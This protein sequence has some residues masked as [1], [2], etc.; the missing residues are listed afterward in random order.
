MLTARRPAESVAVTALVVGLAAIVGATFGLAGAQAGLLFAAVLIGAV[1]AYLLAWPEAGVVLGIF[2]IYSGAP[3]VAVNDHGLPQ[4]VALGVPLMLAV[5]LVS[6]LV[7]RQGLVLSGGLRWVLVLLAI[8]IL[9]AVSSEH[10]SLAL[11]KLGN[12]VIEGVAVFFLITNVVRTPDALRRAMWAIVGASTAL[13][14]ATIVQQFFGKDRYFSGFA[15]LDHAYFLGKSDVLRAQ[16][17]IGDPNYYA[18]ILLVAV[19]L[20]L[21][22]IWRGRSHRERLAAGVAACACIAAIAF[23][24]SRGGAL[25]L[26]AVL[27]CLAFFRYVRAVHVAALVAAFALVLVLVPGYSAR[28]DSLTGAVSS[29]ETSTASSTD[30]LS[31]ASRATENKAA[32]LLFEDH[33]LIGVGQGGFPLYYQEYAPRVGGEIH[34]KSSS[35]LRQ[36]NIS[37]GLAPEREAHNF[38]LGIAADMGFAGL[39]GYCAVLAATVVLLLR[40]RRRWLAQRSDLEGLATAMLLAVVGYMVAAVFLSLAF[41]R[42]FWL[43]IALADAAAYMLLRWPADG[44]G[45]AG[46][47]LRQPSA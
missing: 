41:E 30:D 10:E 1:A 8:Q 33:P 35:D 14:A 39:L 31:A 7:A 23:T 16:G 26:F 24:Y 21:V 25:A 6:R 28:L 42:Y 47:G 37:A 43:L 45:D 46:A 5:P 20:S 19:A 12:F 40:A 29:A 2:L 17:P 13:S 32:L 27:A 38:F 34:T 9:V 15:Q 18:Q 4:V 22:L 36:A 11:S 3:V 44:D